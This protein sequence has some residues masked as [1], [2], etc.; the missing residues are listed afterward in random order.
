[1]RNR[2]LNRPY[3]RDTSLPR[4]RA[5]G[6][7]LVTAVVFLMVLAVLTVM[8]VRS[9]MNETNI[10]GIEADMELARQNAELA[11]RDAEKDIQGLRTDGQF[12]A[13]VACTNL[14]PAGSRPVSTLTVNG[15]WGDFVNTAADTFDAGGLDA[16]SNLVGQ[17]SSSAGTTC[18]VPIWS[19]VDWDDNVTRTCSDGSTR[20]SVPYGRFT[21]AAFQ[22]AATIR[23]PRY[24]IE[25]I[26]PAD[27]GYRLGESTK[28]YFRITAV[29]F[30]KLTGVGAGG[31]PTSVTL[32]ATFSPF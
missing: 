24:I 17:Y 21:E 1:M 26:Q 12:C 20:L 6:F 19:G 10:A 23:R 16:T 2:Y 9:T 30:G 13:V 11:L 22:N 29:G 31:A 28:V 8:A 32:Q 4:G 14:R 27:L 18:G 5:G 25:L 3:A 15:F 7:V